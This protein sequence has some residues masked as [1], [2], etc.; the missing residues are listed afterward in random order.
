MCLGIRPVNVRESP[1]NVSA[2]RLPGSVLLCILAVALED[3]YGSN[4]IL[5]FRCKLDSIHYDVTDQ[6]RV[7]VHSGLH[8][9]HQLLLHDHNHI[10]VTLLICTCSNV[11]SVDSYM[12]LENKTDLTKHIIP[13][14][15]R[16]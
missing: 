4:D 13:S 11:L 14:H 5:Y 9:L 8:C 1:G 10:Q 3:L 16:H 15:T 6:Q 2:L 12:A 7:D